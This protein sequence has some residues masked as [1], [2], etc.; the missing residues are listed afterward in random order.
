[1]QEEVENNEIVTADYYDN[2]YQQV[3]NNLSNI[4]DYQQQIIYNQEQLQIKN[5]NILTVVSC[6]CFIFA[7]FFTFII[8]YFSF[9]R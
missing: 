6:N 7:V 2:Y 4:S 3:L 5:D 8:L 9:K 1:M